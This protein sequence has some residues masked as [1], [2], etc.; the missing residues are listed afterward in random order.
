MLNVSYVQYN[1]MEE[2]S[3]SPEV[4]GSLVNCSS[5]QSEFGALGIWREVDLMHNLALPSDPS[6]SQI[7][8]L[9]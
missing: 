1:R 5:A 2:P 3:Y 9:R 7:L 8:C 4:R 6:I